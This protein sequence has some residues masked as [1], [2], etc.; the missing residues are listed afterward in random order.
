MPNVS[1]KTKLIAFRVPV[2]ISDEA[3]RK[4]K[5]RNFGKGSATSFIKRMAIREVPR[6]HRRKE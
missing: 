1:S 4:E 6:K 3:E 2:E 5:R